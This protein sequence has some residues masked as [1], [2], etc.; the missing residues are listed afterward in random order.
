[1]GALSQL[2][3]A[4]F[5]YLVLSIF[6]FFSS[7]GCK[8]PG[9]S[10]VTMGVINAHIWTGDPD[11]PWAEAMAVQGEEILQVGTTAE[12]KKLFGDSTKVIDAGGKMIT[13]GFNDAHIHFIDGGFGLSSVQLRDATTKDEFIRR[14]SN[15]A[16]TIPAGNWII[17]GD[18]DHTLWVGELPKASWIDSATL[19]HPVFVQ[20][21]DGH[22]GLA[23]TAAMKISNISASTKDV[24]GG[25]ITREPNGMPAGI[26]KDN[27]MALI[28][29]NITEPSDDLKDRALNAA[30][31]YVAEKG[32]TSIQ[33]MGTWGDLEVFKRA[34]QNKTLKTRVYAAVPLSTWKQ[35]A[36]EVD[37]NGRGDNYLKIGGLKGF[38][39]GS[40][41][42]HTAAF[43]K[44]FSDTPADSGFMVTTTEK[45]YSSISSADKAGL[46]LLI[47]SIGDKAIR[48]LLDIFERVEKENGKKDR[49]F[50]IEHFQ[51]IAPVDFPRIA[52]LN[53]VASVQP[54]HAIDDG[55][56]AENYIGPERIKTTYAFKSLLDNKA[57]LAFGSDWFVAPP[58]PLEGIYAAVTR[59][60]IDDKT[61]EGWVPE[62]KITVEQA[63]KAYTSGA[64]YASFD[65]DKKGTLKKGKL[66]DFV[67]LDD[68][69]TKISP[70]KIRDV[71]VITT[72]VGGKITYQRAGN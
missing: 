52:K 10:V 27:A 14:I 47:H 50:R 9:Q 21:L 44:A 61:P 8:S 16:K 19:N 51:H 64:A 70:E 11:Q 18:W 22:M 26:F 25:T 4:G 54:Y 69:I 31:D 15:F 23:N 58:A 40:L 35:L 62:Q 12:I 17:A 57:V 1:M 60:T 55:R 71:K 38:V 3:K 48:E 53:L 33:N 43:Q 67:I 65:E 41:G 29:K 45:L 5:Y 28:Y 63:L 34:H 46:Q 24:D 2:Q 32:V 59:R 6:V 42:S 36:E 68:D 66:A 13:P 56:W 72:V 20:R 30:M 7:T 39:D 37:K 49:R